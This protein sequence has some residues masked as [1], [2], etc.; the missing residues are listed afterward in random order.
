M[1]NSD[2]SVSSGNEGSHIAESS[3]MKA[4]CSHGKPEPLLDHALLYTLQHEA[5]DTVNRGMTT[6][7]EEGPDTVNH[8]MTTVGEEGPDTV[9]RDMTTVGDEAP[10]SLSDQVLKLSQTDSALNDGS[11][12]SDREGE[13]EGRGKLEEEEEEKEREEEENEEEQ[14]EEEEEEV[15]EE[16]EKEEVEGEEEEEEEEEERREAGEETDGMQCDQLK[17]VCFLEEGVDRSP[18][19]VDFDPGGSPSA[20]VESS[21]IAPVND[22]TQNFPFVEEPPTTT[23]YQPS[24]P[25]DQDFESPDTNVYQLAPNPF[26]TL[27]EIDSI[28]HDDVTLNSVHV[29]TQESINTPPNPFGSHGTDCSTSGDD[30]PGG[31]NLGDDPPGGGDLGE[32]LPGGGDLSRGRGLQYDDCLLKYGSLRG[33]TH[34]P[35]DGSPGDAHLPGDSSPG[36]THLPGDGDLPEGLTRDEGLLGDRGLWEDDSLLGDRSLPRDKKLLEDEYL[37]NFAPDATSHSS[38][39]ALSHS[40]ETTLDHALFP[41]TNSSNLQLQEDHFP[42]EVS[43]P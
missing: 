1:E 3:K 39:L 34:L 22:S 36:N 13:G 4:Q 2:G 11:S 9:N 15:E 27:D 29:A 42:P 21:H 32:D 33:D 23:T 28:R 31:G 14:G 17:G 40:L 30:L 37:Y 25:F 18:S 41:E 19:P 7:G 5:P 6:V 16:E 38:S 10:E 26:D 35:G 8:D 24:N 43:S 20:H 12:V